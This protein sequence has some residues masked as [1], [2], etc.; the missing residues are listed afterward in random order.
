MGAGRLPFQ[1]VYRFQISIR[2]EFFIVIVI[3]VINV[4][5]ADKCI[6]HRVPMGPS[7]QT[8]VAHVY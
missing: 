5:I 4:I 8:Y 7:S 1:P 6:V 2:Y 3:V